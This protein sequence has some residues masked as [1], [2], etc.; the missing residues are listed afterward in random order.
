VVAY[1]PRAELKLRTSPRF[2][3]WSRLSLRI[4]LGCSAAGC[5][6]KV[7]P[8]PSSEEVTTPHQSTKVDDDDDMLTSVPN[9]DLLAFPG[10]QGFGAYASG[11]RGGT[12]CVVTSHADQGEGSLQDCVDREGPTF[13]TFRISGV[14]NGPVVITRPNLT[15]AGQ[16][17]EHGV[18]IRGG[19]ICD[20]IY[21]DGSQCENLVIRHLRLRHGESDSLRLGGTSRVIVDHV[22]FGNAADELLEIS[23]ANDITVQNSIFAEP[24]GDHYEFGGVLINYS[25]KAH[26]LTRLSLHHNMWNGV[27]GRLPEFSCEENNDAPGTNCSGHRIDLDLVSNLGFDTV[28]PTWYNRCTGTNEGNEC[29]VGA[30]NVAL[31]L[32]WRQNRMIRRFSDDP[33]P[34][35]EPNVGLAP[36]SKI[37]ADGNVVVNGTIEI[38][39]D[40]SVTSQSESLGFPEIAATASANLVAYM[41]SNVGAFPRDTM[42]SRLIAYLSAEV[43]AR[44]AAWSGGLGVDVGDG[45]RIETQTGG[46]T[47]S[48]GDGMPDDWESTHGLN[49]QSP[50]FGSTV[51]STQGGSGIE[52]CTTGYTDLECY[53]N[54]LADTLQRRQG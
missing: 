16:T 2:R 32:N 1:F 53:L 8:G 18:I 47:D 36:G 48:D 19:I 43:S 6:I 26:P 4:A 7:D 17:S 10:A 39:S 46:P 49:P 12:V 45:L 11:G 29:P 40:D 52:G 20:N 30:D 34:M 22:S 3:R 37:Y 54:E 5:T 31:G 15:L 25:T 35:I 23:R 33:L 44:P 51:L 41:Q 9:D 27:F 13:V 50:A 21:E 38:P 24:V 14:I 42:D 28:M